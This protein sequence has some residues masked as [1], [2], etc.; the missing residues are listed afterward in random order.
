MV[1][2]FQQQEATPAAYPDAPSGL[3]TAAAALDAA[4]IWQRIEAY[5]AHRYT[6]REIVW[7]ISGL[8]GDEWTP[9]IGPLV[10]QTAERWD[11]EAWA[12]VT[13]LSGPVGLCLP[14]DGTFKITAQVGAGDVPAAV[15]E[16]YR[17]YAE[18]SAEIGEN[19][20]LVGHPS[21]TDHSAKIGEAVNESFSRSPTWAARALQLS[22]AADLLRPYRRA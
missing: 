19:G 15:S 1:D 16:A 7:T 11:G 4:M 5:T 10:S 18:Y 9:P 21:H 6:A 22:G 3:S 12:S 13:I 8:A 17:R 2:L 14:S 20:M